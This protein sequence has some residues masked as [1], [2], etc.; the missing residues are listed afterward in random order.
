M[1][2]ELDP[3]REKFLQ[4]ALGEAGYDQTKKADGK[5]SLNDKQNALESAAGK[6]VAES[7]AKIK[8]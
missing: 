2:T 6:E 3:E 5:Y 8:K 4:E 1:K 7:F